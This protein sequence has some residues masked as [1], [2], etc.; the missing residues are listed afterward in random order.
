MQSNALIL[1]SLLC[2]DNC[3][4]MDAA[5]EVKQ[6]GTTFLF[7]KEKVTWNEAEDHCK[8]RCWQILFETVIV[9]CCYWSV[10]NRVSQPGSCDLMEGPQDVSGGHEQDSA[11]TTCLVGTGPFGWC[12]NGRISVSLR[13]E[14]NPGNAEHSRATRPDIQYREDLGN[15]DVFSRHVGGNERRDHRRNLGVRR[16][17]QSQF[18]SGFRRCWDHLFF[19]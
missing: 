16:W 3:T 11:H 4:G 18:R 12:C 9:R 7:F 19:F 13:S 1:M 14:R 5:A 15:G 6:F 8:G 2:L 17:Q 10:E